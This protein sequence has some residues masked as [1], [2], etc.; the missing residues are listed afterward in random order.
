MKDTL[1]LVFIALLS[2]L[3]VNQINAYVAGNL[4]IFV[5]S[6]TSAPK[7]NTSFTPI[8][9]R[10]G[11]ITLYVKAVD[12]GIGLDKIV[13]MITYPNSTRVD[14]TLT[15]DVPKNFTTD[16][17]LL[18]RYNLTFL[19]NDTFNNTFTST[20]LS[21]YARPAF[22]F[23]IS[24][25]QPNLSYAA[26]NVTFL[27][28]GVP[29]AEN[30]SGSSGSM[31]GIALPADALDIKMSTGNKFSATAN[32][33]NISLFPNSTFGIGSVTP[34]SGYLRAYSVNN[35]FNISSASVNFYY[36]DAAYSNEANLKLQVC[37][38]W[39]FT[40]STCGG[41][42]EDIADASQNTTAK[43]ITANLSTFSAFALAETSGGA[44]DGGA[45]SVGG[46]G[47]GVAVK[48][49]FTVEPEILHVSV[50]QD[51]AKKLKLKVKNTANSKQSFKITTDS[52][53][54]VIVIDDEFELQPN[55]EKE[56]RLGVFASEQR[57]PDVY[58]RKIF[59]KGPDTTKTVIIIIDVKPLKPLFDIELE[60]LSD[61]KIIKPDTNILTRLRFSNLGSAKS[62]NV[63]YEITA[64]H[65][66]SNIV[67]LKIQ[68]SAFVE[69]QFSTVKSLKIP[70]VSPDGVY[71][72][73]LRT[74]VNRQTIV[75]SDFLTVRTGFAR[76]DILLVFLGVLL[77]ILITGVIYL[78]FV[79]RRMSFAVKNSRRQ[80]L[81]PVR[82]KRL[83]Y[84]S[85]GGSKKQTIENKIRHLDQA[86]ND[87][88]I[89]EVEYYKMKAVL[90]E[91]LK[92]MK[93]RK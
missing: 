60:V 28:G 1:A 87:D 16:S 3:A 6:D 19:V 88:L 56:I 90:V 17:T 20:N 41:T 75:A 36:G 10:G 68:D 80:V 38:N 35:T 9:I 7:V 47:A 54:M 48:A 58:I 21:F 92:R 93:G 15:N 69:T 89:D 34:P 13:A 39:D 14:V 73:T 74:V 30:T 59:V 77:F 45:V 67:F 24:V 86:F 40:A 26:F 66:D 79:R 91:K 76:V 11:N 57:V 44:G 8:T 51:T 83:T 49:S 61:Y 55:E 64:T 50:L 62:A 12:D 84:V 4:T 52:K 22:S 18:G 5:G 78:Y 85:R 32:G 23:N 72:I 25:I 43:I 70:G 63:N 33:V 46:G 2:I 42:F 65:L 27:H 71:I 29:F 31:S 53:E 81:H 82:A 37:H